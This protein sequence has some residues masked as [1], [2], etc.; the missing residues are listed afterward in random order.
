M[1]RPAK[2]RRRP[3][4]LVFKPHASTS[5]PDTPALSSPSASEASSRF[6]LETRF[7]DAPSIITATRFRPGHLRQKS[8]AGI[9]AK[10]QATIK[11]ERSS[12]TLRAN[13]KAQ[14]DHVGK[15]R[16][17]GIQTVDWDE[18][19]TPLETVR[20]WVEWK[21]EADEEFWQTRTYWIDDKESQDAM[22][23]EWSTGPLPTTS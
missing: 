7:T 14:A 15:A 3:A 2:P 8:S 18:H 21:R 23:G 16:Q 4:N 11:E 20:S 12:A 10:L 1:S 22:A 19:D 17:D 13:R 6:S 5:Q 9:G